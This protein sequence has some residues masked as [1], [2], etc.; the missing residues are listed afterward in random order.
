MQRELRLVILVAL[1]AGAPATA[2]IKQIEVPPSRQQGLDMIQAD[3]DAMPEEPELARHRQAFSESGDIAV[4]DPQGA[5][6]PLYTDLRRHLDNYRERW[7]GLPQI[8]IGEDAKAIGGAT[9]SRV[10]ILR[11]RLGL[12]KQG[13]LDNALKTRLAQY[14]E[15]HGLRSDGKA[16][17][18]TIASLNR[19]A[20]YY[21]QLIQLNLERARRLPTSDYKGKYILVDAGAAKLFLYE[22]GRAVDT[23]KVVVG[24][25]ETETPMLAAALRFSSVNPYWNVPPH[26][27]RSLIAPKVLAQGMTYLSDRGYEVFEDWS[28]DSPVFDPAKI[29]W[30]QVADGGRELRVRQLPGG[31]NS[32]GQIKFMMPNEY[33]IYLHDTPNKALFNDDERWVSNGCIRVEDAQRLARWLYGEM[34]KASSSNREEQVQL[35]QP[36]PVY[37]TYFT[38]ASAGEALSFRKDRYNRDAKL[39][40]RFR[41]QAGAM[42]D[43]AARVPNPKAR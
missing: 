32:M 35:Q 14:Q 3:E 42:I 40:P 12:P 37:V 27:V 17:P 15:A 8:V 6:H 9:D 19:G 39:L 13:G 20:A 34:P 18:E 11:E 38:V 30:Q 24:A 16:G 21:E 28:E 41:A 22:N 33:G 36:V 2:T 29:D 4:A 1:V 10:V 43:P 23:M 5:V 25:P 26:L 31:A 7:S